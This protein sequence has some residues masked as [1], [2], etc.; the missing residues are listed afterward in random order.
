MLAIFVVNPLPIK[1]GSDDDS[2]ANIVFLLGDSIESTLAFAEITAG[3]VAT[4]VAA[5][6]GGVVCAAPF[7]SC[8]KLII[9]R[10]S[11]AACAKSL[12]PDVVA[13]ICKNSAGLSL[14]A[15]Y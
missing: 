4:T 3:N 6:T 9:A 14:I 13:L 5:A 12:V 2:S 1:V 10:V 8:I 15:M 11:S 7:F